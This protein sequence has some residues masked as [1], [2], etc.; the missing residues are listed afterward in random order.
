MA[1]SRIEEPSHAGELLRRERLAEQVLDDYARSG[2]PTE[3]HAPLSESW[4][5]SSEN[6]VGK[7][8]IL[9]TPI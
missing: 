1:K 2:A 8:Y 4:Q 6:I 5:E 3:E 7:D 9:E